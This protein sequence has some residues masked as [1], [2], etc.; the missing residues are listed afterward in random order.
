MTF[1]NLI[2]TY[3]KYIIVFFVFVLF[4][5]LGFK[6]AYSI[7]QNN[8]DKLTSQYQLEKQKQLEDFTLKQKNQSEK[9]S[10]IV[11][12]LNKKLSDISEQSSNQI[13]D[14]KSLLNKDKSKLDQCSL[15]EETLDNLNS[16]F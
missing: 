12:E 3:K 1:I 16:I 11:S 14:L 2:L 9:D 8:I 6:L 15:N 13:N 7:Q 5:C 4:F 10:Q